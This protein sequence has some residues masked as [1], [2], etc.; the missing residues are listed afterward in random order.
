[1]LYH[2]RDPKHVYP[3]Q[4]VEIETDGPGPAA[5]KALEAMMGCSVHDVAE[6]VITEALETLEVTVQQTPGDGI[7]HV[8]ERVSSWWVPVEHAQAE[9]IQEYWNMQDDKLN[10]EMRRCQICGGPPH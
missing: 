8:L 10:A 9:A 1:M 4:A 3:I 5:V 6:R 7:E 2:V